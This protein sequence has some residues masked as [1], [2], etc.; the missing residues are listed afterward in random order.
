V[1]GVIAFVGH[2]VLEYSRNYLAGNSRQP[3]FMAGLLLTLSAAVLMTTAGNLLQLLA[4]WIATSLALHRLLIFYSE[5]PI[6]RLAARKKF[7][8]ARLGD[9]CLALAAALLY[10]SFE[11]GDIAALLAGAGEAGVHGRAIE[12]SAILIATAAM[13]KSAQFPSH[14]WLVEVMETPTPVSALLHAGVVNAGGFLV[15]RFADVMV[16]SAGAMQSLI[17]VGGLTAV[18][19]SVVMSAQPNI[20]VSLGYSTVAQ[21][22]FMLMQCGFGAFSSAGLHLASHSFYKAHGFL[23]SGNA[24]DHVAAQRA[25]AGDRRPG[26]IA[27]IVA[28]ALALLIFAGI[29]RLFDHAITDSPAVLAL[30]A[31]FI[32]GL[33][34]WLSRGAGNAAVLLRVVPLAAVTATVFFLLQIGAANWFAPQLPEVPAVS[35]SGY[36]LAVL[37]VAA[38]AALTVLQVVRLPAAS[39]LHRAAW[40]HLRNGLYANAFLN[41]R[42]GASRRDATSAI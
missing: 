22:G 7:I 11:T 26:S 41:R 14:G 5:R 13:L 35:G 28:L 16:L 33:F 3:E 34:V 25:V 30:G 32:M 15:F 6:A 36:T 27:L 29:G 23:A 12:A 2:L 24:V 31:I 4:G 39:A 10:L 8:V 9:L 42:L 21:M 37:I 1:F 40:V 19:G 17:I 38:F 20:K 18:F